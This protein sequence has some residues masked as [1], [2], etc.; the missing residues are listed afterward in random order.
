MEPIFGTG[1]PKWE[2]KL[3]SLM[4]L[5]FKE[6]GAVDSITLEDKRLMLLL[7][8]Y[9]CVCT[10]VYIYLKETAKSIS[11]FILCFV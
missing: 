4:E 10:H 6:V 9:M 1:L 7:T 5:S 11:T 8:R 3:F 2:H